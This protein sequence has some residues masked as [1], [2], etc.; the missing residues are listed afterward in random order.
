MSGAWA[1]RQDKRDRPLAKTGVRRAIEMV[2]E[3][4]ANSPQRWPWSGLGM[5]TLSAVYRP[6]SVLLPHPFN[7]CPYPYPYPYPKSP[8]HKHPHSCT[9]ISRA[10]TDVARAREFLELS[11]VCHSCV[12]FLW[13]LCSDFA[14]RNYSFA[15]NSDRIQLRAHLCVCVCLCNQISIAVTNSLRPM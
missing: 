3:R 12:V 6:M 13:T 7:S 15:R 8:N 1:E 10:E 5:G 14:L 4:D 2:M 11:P 9:T